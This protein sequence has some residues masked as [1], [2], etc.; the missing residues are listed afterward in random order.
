MV[1]GLTLL[2]VD[3]AAIP[4]SK[5]ASGRKRKQVLM[6]ESDESGA[7]EFPQDSGSDWSAAGKVAA[8][9]A[10][11]AAE[12]DVSMADDSEDTPGSTD[13]GQKNG[14]SR[15]R[16]KPSPLKVSPAR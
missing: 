5:V 6:S 9:E 14:S 2:D 1:I 16:Q 11:E 7:E 12:D 10:A 13:A 15:K 3:A 4:A 8:A